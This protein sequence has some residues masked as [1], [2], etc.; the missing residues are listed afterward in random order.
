MSAEIKKLKEIKLHVQDV[1]YTVKVDDVTP[2]VGSGDRE[3]VDRRSGTSDSTVRRS[4]R[5]LLLFHPGTD[6]AGH[7]R[8]VDLLGQRFRQVQLED[9]QERHHRSDWSAGA[10]LRLE[11][12]HTR[13]YRTVLVLGRGAL[14]V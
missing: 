2:Q 3:R 7:D 13:Y 1:E 11:I 10:D 5:R 8:G 14:G 4:D 12:R 9:R 6:G